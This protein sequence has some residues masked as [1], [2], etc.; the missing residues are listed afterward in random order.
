MMHMYIPGFDVD[1][2]D[3]SGHELMLEFGQAETPIITIPVLLVY[4]DIVDQ[5]LTELT[6]R[7]LLLEDLLQ[8]IL[9]G[10]LLE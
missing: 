1:D 5:I 10:V 6:P 2:V 4:D 9:I 7:L 3:G 8:L